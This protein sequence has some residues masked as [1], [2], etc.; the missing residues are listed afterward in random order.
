MLIGELDGYGKIQTNRFSLEE[1]TCIKTKEIGWNK[2]KI[3]GYGCFTLWFR[4]WL[5]KIYLK[6]LVRVIG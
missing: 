4:F 6:V 2:S 5:K 3:Y 1:E